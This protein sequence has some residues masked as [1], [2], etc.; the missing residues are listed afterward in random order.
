MAKP[1]CHRIGIPSFALRSLR[2]DAPSLAAVLFQQLPVV[3]RA[4]GIHDGDSDVAQV[5]FR[6]PLHFQTLSQRAEPDAC[7]D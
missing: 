6:S 7:K 4:I 2:Q 1:R 5:S 3:S